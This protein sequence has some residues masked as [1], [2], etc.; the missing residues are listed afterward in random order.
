M[1]QF[2]DLI[3]AFIIVNLKNLENIKTIILK[4][5]NLVKKT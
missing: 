3:L 1:L 2:F 4:F 5:F